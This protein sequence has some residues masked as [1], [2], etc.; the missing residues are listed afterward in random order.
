VTVV[1]PTVRRLVLGRLKISKQALSQ[2]AR[3]VKD[4]YGP[5]TTDEA[6][7]ILAHLEGIDLSRYLP[8]AIVDRV[9]ALVPRQAISS[10]SGPPKLSSKKVERKKPKHRHFYPLIPNAEVRVA[11]NLGK[12]VYPQVF[13]L[14]NS[15]RNLIIDRLSKID[16][17]WW[18][19][20][21]PQDVRDTVAR[22][23]IKEKRYPYRD[24]RGRHPIFYSNF[25]DLKKIIVANQATFSDAIIDIEWF[26]AKMDE[27][28]MARNGL[29]HCIS[30]SRDDIS[31]ILLFNRDWA[32]MLNSAGIR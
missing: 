6:V 24:A 7:Y 25:A 1:N 16:R 9:R 11:D 19:K 5:M 23:I 4:A 22:T 27:V 17:N 26:K 29:A 18:D 12:D 10:L 31:R 15:I 32:R 13:V 2:R 28:Y 14:E 8:L 20:F 30:L 3:R 21:A